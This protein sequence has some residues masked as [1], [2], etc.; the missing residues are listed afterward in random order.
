[1]NPIRHICGLTAALAGLVSALLAF[2][3]APAAFASPAPPWGLRATEATFALGPRSL[4]PGWHKHP[5]PLPPVHIHQ[6]VHVSVQTVIAGGTPGWYIALIAIAAALLF[7]GAAVRA[8]RAWTG[9]R[10][11]VTAAPE[12]RVP[13]ADILSAP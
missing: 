4:P 12:P 5:A 3:A 1:M 8:Y 10:E 2:T 9:R 11:P 7:A 6:P 13:G